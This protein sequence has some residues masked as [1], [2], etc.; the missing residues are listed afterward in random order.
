MKTLATILAIGLVCS[1]TAFAQRPG[2]G[3]PS[4]A[5][6]GPP[7]GMPAGGPPA[8]SPAGTMG[9]GNATGHDM[10]PNAGHGADLGKQ[11]PDQVLSRNTQLS[12]NLEKDLPKGMTAQ[13]ACSGFGNLGQCVAAVHV[14]HNLDIPFDQLKAK[15]ASGDSLGKAIHS[16][17]P[18]ADAKSETKKAEKQ[19]KDD[20]KESGS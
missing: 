16:L 7:T 10:G 14:S 11:S 15:M 9:H 17:K 18:D 12:S 20:L 19:A 8:T 3:R 5:P 2:A 13:Q 4:G 6:G 1:M